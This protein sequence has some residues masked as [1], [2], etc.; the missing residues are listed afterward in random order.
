[1]LPNLYVWHAAQFVCEMG[2]QKV[3]LEGDSQS[4][5]SAL[6]RVSPCGSGCGQLISDTQV[7]LSSLEHHSFTH[8]KRDAN[9]VV[10]G[11]AILALSQLLDKVWVDG[12]PPDYTT[13]CTCGTSGRLLINEILIFPKK[14]KKLLISEFR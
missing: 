3:V 9:K 11:I 5:I 4:V 6:Q 7:I 14:K 8:V 13:Y 12:C 1:M 10:H 2:Y